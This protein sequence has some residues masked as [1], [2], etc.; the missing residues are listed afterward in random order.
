MSTETIAKIFCPAKTAMQSGRAKT[1]KW[2][3][4]YKPSAPMTPDALM[5]WNSGAN[6]LAQIQ[7]KFPTK[8][9]AIAYAKAKNIAYEVAD[10]KPIRSGPKSYA[11]NF[12]FNRKRAYADNV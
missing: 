1:H 4:E 9:A 5:G 6:T 10:P 11:A 12:A 8:E 3:L 7:L 2:I